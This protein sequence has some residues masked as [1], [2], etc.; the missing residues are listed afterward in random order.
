VVRVVRLLHHHHLVVGVVGVV[1]AA[2]FRFHFRF[3]RR[4]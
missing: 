3:G 4:R 1:A 2:L